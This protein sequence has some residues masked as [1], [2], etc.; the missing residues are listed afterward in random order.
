MLSSTGR[1]T[2]CVYLEG[3]GMLVRMCLRRGRNSDT[4]RGRVALNLVQCDDRM[5]WHPDRS[6]VKSSAHHARAQENLSSCRLKIILEPSFCLGDTGV[7]ARNAGI[8]E[9][10]E[11]CFHFKLQLQTNGINWE[12]MTWDMK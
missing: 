6:F 5:A 8:F 2:L 12:N 11:F 9:Q 4:D 1:S 7:L 3:Y 10:Q